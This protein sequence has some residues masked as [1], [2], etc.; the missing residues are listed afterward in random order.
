MQLLDSGLSGFWWLWLNA[1]EPS[2]VNSS[3]LQSLYMSSVILGKIAELF[4]ECFL[5]PDTI[6]ENL[7]KFTFEMNSL[8]S[9][10]TTVAQ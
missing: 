10:H 6:Y 3:M 2:Q 8:C 1:L 5:P 9:Y 4:F 7:G